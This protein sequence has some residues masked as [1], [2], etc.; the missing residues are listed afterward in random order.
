MR[1]LKMCFVVMLVAQ[2]TIESQVRMRPG[3]YEY[4]VDMDFGPG[5]KAATDA[6]LGA[7]GAG[8]STRKQLQC[9]TAADVKDMTDANSI[10]KVF[11]RDIEA[12][13]TCKVSGVKSTA[14]R[15]GECPK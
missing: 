6:V 12:D 1:V 8:T 9:V 13:G 15:V 3:Y 5:S 4:T 11:T 2:A 14:K 7:A 10:V